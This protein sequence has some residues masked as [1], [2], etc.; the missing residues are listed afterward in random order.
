MTLTSEQAVKKSIVAA[1]VGGAGIN[2]VDYI[3]RKEKKLANVEYVL[4][5]TDAVSLRASY[6]QQKIQLGSSGVSANGDTAYAKK[7]AEESE[8]QIISALSDACLFIIIAGGGG[9]TG[10]GA[11][12]VIAQYAKESGIPTVAFVTKPF[13]FEGAERAEKADDLIAELKKIADAVCI[14]PNEKLKAEA[15]DMDISMPLAVSFKSVYNAIFFL[16]DIIH[17]QGQINT[18]YA[19]LMHL[20]RAK[21]ELY[22]GACSAEYDSCIFAAKGALYNPL[23]ETTF[24]GAKDVLVSVKTGNDASLDVL[25]SAIT[26]IYDEAD[27]DAEI[28]V[29]TEIDESFVNKIGIAVFAVK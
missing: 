16:R 21:G 20:L 17:S 22:F 11:A 15:D 1:G 27:P 3:V 28:M 29:G 10:S 2:C 6:A 7:A 4:A 23:L 5:D 13:D 19:D 14:M 26:A 12:P 18:D 9:G 8:Q 24:H 25:K